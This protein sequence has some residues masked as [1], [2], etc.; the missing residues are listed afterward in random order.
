MPTGQYSIAVAAIDS[1][2]HLSASSNV[3]TVVTPA[4]DSGPDIIPPS[5]PTDVRVIA[6]APVML[7]W[8]PSTDNVG[9]T[10]YDVY[11]W[12]GL[13]AP[14]LLGTTT[15]TTLAV[16][17]ATPGPFS[18]V[19]V[20]ARDAAGNRS[21]AGR[22]DGPLPPPTSPPP[23]T[24]APPA[25]SPTPSP[26]CG[27]T[28]TTVSQWPGGFAATVRIANSASKRV[29]GW[30]L[31]FAFGGDQ[32]ITSASNAGFSQSGANA[33]LRNGARD[34]VIPPHGSVIV[35]IR[36]TW[37]ASDAPPSTFRLNGNPCA[38]G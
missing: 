3:L 23:P 28:Y 22:L 17:Q 11:R 10:G 36:G 16:T 31:A 29:N 14:V 33:T 1:L 2:G 25:P 32:R 35:S 4:S 13:Y 9:V 15:G 21:I 34:A 30:R 27:V 37:R 26:T 24:S 6:G 18:V 5:A 7:A 12:D 19:F 38:G 8:S 20:R